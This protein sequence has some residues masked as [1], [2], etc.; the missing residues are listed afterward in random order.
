VLRRLLAPQ[1]LALHVVAVAAVVACAWLGLWQLDRTRA[2][3]QTAVDPAPV[4]IAAVT[5]VEGSLRAGAAGRLVTVEGTYDASQQFTVT[6]RGGDPWVLTVLQVGAGGAARPGVL[7]VRGGLAAGAVAPAPPTGKVE[8]TGRLQPA[9]PS[10]GAPAAGS[11]E[12]AAVSPVDL[13]ARVPY[14][15]YDGYV[16]LRSQVPP[17]PT[18]LALVPSPAVPDTPPGYVWQHAGYVALW[19]AFGLFALFFWYRLVRDRLADS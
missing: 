3:N 5:Q 11:H 9:E 18:S 4:P 13:L 7:V 2:F 6:D 19:W 1:M 17:A 12:L 15:L 10:S 16:V 14:P 8:V